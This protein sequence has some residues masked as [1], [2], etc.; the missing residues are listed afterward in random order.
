MLTQGILDRIAACLSEL[1]AQGRTSVGLV[2]GEHIQSFRDIARDMN[3]VLQDFNPADPQAVAV[4]TG[5]DTLN[6]ESQAVRKAA[7]LAGRDVLVIDSCLD[8]LMVMQAPKPRIRFDATNSCNLRC[9]YCYRRAPF[10]KLNPHMSLDTFR[11]LN[12]LGPQDPVDTFLWDDLPPVFTSLE[13]F[14]TMLRHIGQPELL[15]LSCATEPLIHPRIGDIIQAADGLNTLLVTNA[16]LLDETHI[17]PIIN[18]GLKSLVVSLDSADDAFTREYT[19]L[20]ASRVLDSLRLLQK[21]KR[22]AGSALPELTI[23]MVLFKENL[24][25]IGALL[26]ALDGLGVTGL[27]VCRLLPRNDAFK[28]LVPA[29]AEIASLVESIRP[30]SEELGIPVRFGYHE[31]PRSER[32]E[33]CCQLPLSNFFINAGGDIF[34]CFKAHIGNIFRESLKTAMDRNM[35]RLLSASRVDDPYCR[36]C[37]I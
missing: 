9:S 12:N 2:P 3:G 35:E 10:P 6:R 33:G 23:S 15:A 30:L 8:E 34:T 29:N 26:R 7:A 31:T 14:K 19:G 11:V 18:N 1:K 32:L 16:L 24:N 36:H 22:E 4:L 21:M 20:R 5:L 37:F 13:D 27:N 17:A 28:S 25:H